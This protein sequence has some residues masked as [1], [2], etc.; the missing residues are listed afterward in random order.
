MRLFVALVACL[1]MYGISSAPA[2]AQDLQEAERQLDQ[3]RQ[4][5]RD[6]D[7]TGMPENIKQGWRDLLRDAEADVARLRAEEAQAAAQPAA[8][9]E[10]P[11]PASSDSL[12][13]ELGA[14]LPVLVT[15]P[16]TPSSG[17]SAFVQVNTRIFL[18]GGA[19]ML[20]YSLHP[21]PER[22]IE[23]IRFSGQVSGPD[24]ALYPFEAPGARAEP[25]DALGCDHQ[26]VAIT[27]LDRHEK[28]LIQHTYTNGQDVWR[29]RDM[30]EHLLGRFHIQAFPAPWPAGSSLTS[31]AEQAR[32]KAEADAADRQKTQ[33][34]YDEA[35]QRSEAVAAEAARKQQA[36]EAEQ[37]KFR[38][39]QAQY[40]ADK[41]ANDAAVAKAKAAR[42]D[43]ERRLA[44]YEASIGK[45]RVKLP[46]R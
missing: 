15:V 27:S 32:A 37:A 39:A 5:V 33:K 34:I 21:V 31:N 36:Y 35:K 38:N 7:S 46:D 29:R 9:P 24:G 19:I 10:P 26:T 11:A 16:L 25:G 45:A 42:E 3:M 18:C 28:D 8:A 43:Y 30:V 13:A 23:A 4:A 41:A 2:R 22:R 6:M 17:E 14:P 1:A 44:E 40:L 12:P 20:S